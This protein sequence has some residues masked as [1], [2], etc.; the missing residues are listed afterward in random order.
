MIHAQERWFLVLNEEPRELLRELRNLL[1]ESW[2]PPLS[3]CYC[4][5]ATPCEVLT[6]YPNRTPRK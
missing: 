2:Q 6:T 5:C 3:I 4:D 1:K